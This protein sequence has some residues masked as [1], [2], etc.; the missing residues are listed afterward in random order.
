MGSSGI[1]ILKLES[2][3]YVKAVLCCDEGN[4]YDAESDQSSAF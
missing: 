3:T 1:K 2:I 4:Q